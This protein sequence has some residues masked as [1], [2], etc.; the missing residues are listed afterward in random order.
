MSEAP[1]SAVSRLSVRCYVSVNSGPTIC[2]VS[3]V[4]SLLTGETCYLL[5]RVRAQAGESE[6][7]VLERREGS[8]HVRSIMRT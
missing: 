4:S 2:Y 3:S 6:R 7:V 1:G 8:S 5:P